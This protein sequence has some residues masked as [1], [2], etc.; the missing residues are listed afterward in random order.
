MNDERYRMSLLLAWTD[1]A[2]ASSGLLFELYST[3]GV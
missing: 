1:S 3:V 2:Y